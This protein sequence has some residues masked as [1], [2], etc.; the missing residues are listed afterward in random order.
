MTH[1]LSDMYEIAKHVQR[2]TNNQIP[3]GLVLAQMRIESSH[4]TSPLAVENNNFGGVTSTEGGYMSFDSRE[5]FADYYSR[6][7]PL[8][9]VNGI[10]DPQQYAKTLYENG[11]F[12]EADYYNYVN[13]LTSILEEQE[14]DGFSFYGDDSDLV[15]YGAQPSML[16]SYN[17]VSDTILDFSTI[18]SNH[19]GDNYTT[20][21]YAD[22]H[23]V[24]LQGVAIKGL[25][26]IGLFAS[27]KGW[28]MVTITGGAE[29]WTH[30]GGEYSHHTGV[31]GDIWIDGVTGDT[32]RG[33]ELVQFAHANGWSINWEGDHWDIDFTGH[34]S[35]DPQGGRGQGYTGD[36]L[37]DIFLPAY[38]QATDYQY[39]GNQDED[40]LGEG[41]LDAPR[42][43][44]TWDAVKTNFMDEF[45]TSGIASALQ[46]VWGGVTHSGKWWYEKKDPV[47]QADY[48]Y[49]KQALAGDVTAQEF[50]LLNGRDSE[51][52]RWLTNQKLV[53]RKR[54]EELERWK[55]QNDSILKRVAVAGGAVAGFVLDPTN[56]IPMGE[57]AAGTKMLARMGKSLRNVSKAREIAKIAATT[58][59]KYG[60][61]QAPLVATVAGNDYLRKEF[62]GYEVNYAF[63]IGAA[64]LASTVIGVAGDK[65]YNTVWLNRKSLLGDVA[66]VADRA[67][68]KVYYDV[69]TDAR[70]THGRIPVST[71]N[72]RVV[73]DAAD[74]VDVPFDPNVKRPRINQKKVRSETYKVM[75]EHHDKDFGDTFRNNSV[76]KRF[77]QNKRVLAVSYDDASRIVKELS[78]KDLPKDTKAFYVPNED[79]A[80]IIKDNVTSKDGKHIEKVLAHEFAIHAGLRKTLGEE[81][82]AKLMAEVKEKMNRE[83][84]V[85]NHIRRQYDTQDPEEVIAH[86][87]EDGWLGN[88]S[89]SFV[90]S[91][92]EKLNK[93]L[94]ADGYKVKLGQADIEKM[95][96]QQTELRR[97]N[98]RGYHFNDDGTT[99][100]GGLQ[101]SRG[102]LL[103]PQLWADFIELE[104]TIMRNTQADLGTHL[105][106]G[107]K[108]VLE[109]IGSMVEQ[110]GSGLMRN[111][112]SNTARRYA[113][114]LFSDVR[115]RG[116]G[117]VESIPAEDMKEIIFKRLY[118]HIGAYN[119]ERARWMWRHP[120]INL[121]TSQLA[122]D[123]MATLRY[124]EKYAG[125]TATIMGEVP[126]EV[127]RAVDLLHAYR[128]E[129]IVIGKQS[130]EM[131]GAQ[132]DNII[133]KDWESVDNEL[134]RTVDTYK[135]ERF[136][137]HFNTHEEAEK[138]LADYYRTCA[139]LSVIK[140]KMIRDIHLKNAKT[141]AFNEK[142]LA[143]DPNFKAQE[144]LPEEVTDEQV[145]EWLDARVVA[146]AKHALGSDYDTLN[147][148]SMGAIGHL[149]FFDV[150]I[151]MDTSKVMLMHK[152]TK[153]EFEFS[154]DNNLR[155]FDLDVLMRRN[156]QRFAGEIAVKNVFKTEHNFRTVLNSIKEETKIAVAQRHSNAAVSN[157]ARKIEDAIYEIRGARP[158]EDAATKVGILA[159]LG[160]NVSY[161]K[162]AANMGF[163]QMGEIGGAMAYG[164]ASRLFDI[165]PNLRK[166]SF[167]IRHGK[168]LSAEL[169]HAETMLWGR[170]I[171]ADIW[172]H[173][174]QDQVAHDALSARKDISGKVLNFASDV[175]KYGGKFT[176]SLNMLPKTTESMYKG[177]RAEYIVDALKWAWDGKF[178]AMRSPFTDAK[179]KASDI[180][181]DMA[182]RI[183]EW[184]RQVAYYNDATGK[185]EAFRRDALYQWREKDPASYHKFVQMGQTHAERA[186]VSGT[187]VG[188]KNIAKANS[189]PLRFAL[190]FK[191][192]ALRA[193]NGQTM[194]AVTAGDFDDAIATGM[195]I[196]SNLG[197][198]MARAGLTYGAYKASGMDEYAEEYYRKM[199]DEMQ[200]ARVA[201]FR[202][203]ILG[204]PASFGN[205]IYEA[206]TG[207]PSIRT[208]VD[209]SVR[210]PKDRDEGDVAGSIASQMPAV[211]DT[212]GALLTWYYVGDHFNDGDATKGDLKKL[213]RTIPIPNFIPFMTVLDNIVEGSGLPDKRPKVKGD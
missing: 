165:L 65:L 154:F 32:S 7:L 35:R 20:A 89:K 18:Q 197:A 196:A 15:S 22:E 113:P 23:S 192:Y 198:Y 179:L 132:A 87:V 149:N 55:E 80:V 90:S 84:T 163:A 169:Q 100:F 98:W 42:K 203:A 52:I 47:T 130:A 213:L 145:K 201:A 2:Q 45:T 205:D 103:N 68:T 183:T 166:L 33:E 26:K 129:Q 136:L 60:K 67:E 146:A 158:N 16:D 161:M 31:K 170:S 19:Q 139:D 117:S 150:R 10:T 148:K 25:N 120:K 156:A 66:K 97:N 86:A 69:A 168:A 189:L 93:V 72:G 112:V 70:Q 111:S 39:Y 38:A 115:G 79:Y 30:A 188:N 77:E 104:P 208:T 171:E 27:D 59:V 1:T 151:P 44:S 153:N 184:L 81:N 71:P 202:S 207:A 173:S 195:S 178:S 17:D 180:T 63:D 122:F 127:E 164:G 152:G 124:N 128:Q 6:F 190:Q 54:A 46:F 194:R 167:D 96:Q 78:G 58:A 212:L 12:G 159:R 138:A 147:K 43:L 75:K 21:L 177:L 140:E 174:F 119:D 73:A 199:F 50:V 85:F 8:F 102:N 206:L 131:F 137:A 94:R 204:T 76:Y 116:G 13:A 3:A 53:D 51:Q 143:E 186:I 24:G 56:L 135:R 200:L 108:R 106:K 126:E 48:D 110:G 193:L 114:L 62:G 49:V 57:V 191:D 11:Y 101:Y 118:R 210:R 82:F 175:V 95:L 83:S 5:A 144:V 133:Q 92:K 181:D 157:A 160:L 74:D 172:T 155:S 125:H 105:P 28:G 185:I 142:R 209:R 162:N 187:R 91:I 107:A 123:E 34:D 64:V 211:K 176:S 36:S 37:T 29:R 61:S 4:G 109:E 40:T 14:R 141:Q 41:F 182:E 134:W 9:H 121:R 88:S 99:A